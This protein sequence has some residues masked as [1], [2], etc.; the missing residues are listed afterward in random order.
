MVGI[1]YREQHVAQALISR[2][3]N[4]TEVNMVGSRGQSVE[5]V[6]INPSAL[7]NGKEENL[8]YLAGE[9]ASLAMVAA[10]YDALLGYS[11]KGTLSTPPY[12]CPT[13]NCTCDPF[14]TLGV[15]SGCSNIT[16]LLQPTLI[17]VNTTDMN[18]S[19][20]E[21]IQ[22]GADV[23]RWT[24]PSEYYNLSI[25]SMTGDNATNFPTM[26]VTA[27]SD[28]N[29][30]G[31]ENPFLHFVLVN[32]SVY[33]A[34]EATALEC[35]MPICL[36]E[37]EADVQN[38][39]FSE[40]RT[41]ATVT[42]DTNDNYNYVSPPSDNETSFMVSFEMLGGL[43]I[44]LDQLFFTMAQGQDGGLYFD[45]YVAEAL[46]Y[47][48]NVSA[49]MDYLAESMSI[50]LRE[51]SSGGS[52]AFPGLAF[53]TEYFFAVRW[54]WLV[55]PTAIVLSAA[56]FA[57]LVMIETERSRTPLWKNSLLAILSLE[58]D[59]IDRRQLT[60]S[61]QTPE[62]FERASNMDHIAEGIQ[63]QLCLDKKL[64]KTRLVVTETNE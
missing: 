5:H 8:I 22:V 6:V 23:I 32:S 50:H 45:S 64:G 63:V 53:T 11:T 56:V 31:A 35:G 46:W 12:T 40:N 24:L 18:S 4:G 55:F 27:A 7:R 48:D 60:L 28:L 3:V 54:A 30:S 25:L 49:Q 21:A 34:T 47:S 17:V 41:E 62:D 59:D 42:W 10:I 51:A 38:G 20:D 43:R 16:N 39:L 58:V 37:I 61:D 14:L 9:T 29:F 2:A 44:M 33:N 1:S 36:Q 52:D 26:N 15:C 19:I 57:G 13:G